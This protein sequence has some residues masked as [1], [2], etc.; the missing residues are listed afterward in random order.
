MARLSG[1]LF[2]IGLAAAG[3]ARAA[4]L[5]EQ[6]DWIRKPS[7]SSFVWP[8]AALTKG[9]DGEATV[10]CKVSPQGVLF[11]CR[12]LSEAPAGLG[13][14]AA[15]LAMTPQFL[16]RPLIKNGQPVAGGTVRIPIHW[17]GAHAQPDP[18]GAAGV[19]NIEWREAPTFDEVLAAYPAKPRAE[20][21]TGHATLSCLYSA[22]GHLREC[23][24]GAEEPRGL[25][26]GTAA[27]RLEKLFR[28]PPLSPELAKS[29]KPIMTQVNV[30]FASETLSG[31]RTVGKPHWVALPGFEELKAS[32]PSE[33]SKAHVLKARVVLVCR[34]VK[35]GAV[36]A[37]RTDSEEPKGLG[38]GAAALS[39]SHAFRLSVWTDEGLPTIGGEVTIPIR[40]D[41]SD[42]PPQ[43]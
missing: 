21:V 5:I 2:A 27:V 37:C 28:G 13:F 1:A 16:M 31:V 38:F 24:V 36:E 6:P 3:S 20:G 22:D 23:R 29:K 40:Y 43:P 32:F 19:A 18:L 12:V 14:G 9:L 4:D 17:K 25:G 26:F 8:R 11:E 10:G 39:L 42:N 15:A 7:A 35:E 30:A 33:A 34:V 41:F